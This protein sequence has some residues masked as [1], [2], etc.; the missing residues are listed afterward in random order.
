MAK[1]I[2]RKLKLIGISLLGLYSVV[3]ISL[4]GRLWQS[5]ALATG[6]V[7]LS[8]NLAY[9]RYLRDSAF[10][11]LR[12]LAFTGV[13]GLVAGFLVGLLT[14]L[15]MAIKTGLHSHGPEFQQSEFIWVLSQIPI[16]SSAGLLGGLGI[17]LLVIGARK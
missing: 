7:L 8:S 4:E 14:L 5:I 6:F 17:S 2:N 15:F 16:W 1:P 12:Q 13:L 11:R 9:E 10:S 3:W